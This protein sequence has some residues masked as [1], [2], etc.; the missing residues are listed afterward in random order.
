MNT[1]HTS[2][3]IKEQN[4]EI[5]NEQ[6]NQQDQETGA[7]ELTSLKQALEEKEDKYLRLYAEFDNFK[8]RSAKERIEFIKLANRDMIKDLLPVMDDLLRAKETVEKSTD[9]EGIKVG[10]DLIFS[11]LQQT[12]SN[13]GLQAM[14]VKGEVFDS[15]MHEAITEIP[16]PS[17]DMKGKI[18]DV[19]EHGYKLN[20]IIIRYPKVVI[21][22]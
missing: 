20:D 19:V 18:I 21:G 22:K 14:S 9:I 10:M 16:A 6:A 7:D 2:E 8:K 12:L 4:E 15:E 5:H 11:K 17:E 13:K 3:E 1:D